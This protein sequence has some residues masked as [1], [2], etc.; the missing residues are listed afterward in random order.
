MLSSR[1][2]LRNTDPV[3][4]PFLWC[5]LSYLSD[6]EEEMFDVFN[7]LDPLLKQNSPSVIMATSTLYMEWASAAAAT[8]DGDSGNAE[9]LQQVM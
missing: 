8:T 5:S 2:L 3:S 4:T 1:S 6:T 9:L 7:V